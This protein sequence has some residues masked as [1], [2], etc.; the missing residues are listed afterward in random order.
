MGSCRPAR[1]I[2]VGAEGT[3]ATGVAEVETPD[4]AVQPE[5]VEAGFDDAQ[6]RALVAQADAAEVAVD[7]LARQL[8][9][10]AQLVA[11]AAPEHAVGAQAEKIGRAGLVEG[12]PAGAQRRTK[13][14]V[15]GE[16]AVGP[17]AIGNRVVQAAAAAVASVAI[18][19]VAGAQQQRVVEFQRAVQAQAEVAA[20]ASCG[21]AAEVVQAQAEAPAR[22]AAAFTQED[23]RGAGLA[24][25]GDVGGEIDR[26]QAVQLVQ[27]L[28][29]VAQVQRLAEHAGEG[30]AQR[31]RQALV[32]QFDGLDVAFVDQDI[33]AL[34]G[35]RG[36][37]R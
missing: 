31:Y 35:L 3:Q 4:R 25:R 12:L 13:F 17:V 29:Q 34:P 1:A 21:Q 16:Q 18:Q 22:G 6:P 32:V 2:A 36:L 27:A 24:A 26:A 33:Q 19:R 7:I 8:Q 20:I 9:V 15:A 37:A 14:G 23:P 5:Q 11:L 30:A 28:L 10:G